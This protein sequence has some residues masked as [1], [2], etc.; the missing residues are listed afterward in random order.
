MNTQPKKPRPVLIGVGQMVHHPQ[1]VDE[2]KS[3]LD[4]IDVA[5]RRAEE[6]CGQPGLAAKIDTLQLVNII[7]WT[8]DPPLKMLAARLGANP[9][10]SGYTWIGASAPQWFVNRTAEMIVSGQAR[11]A[12]ICGG[13]AFYSRKLIIKARRATNQARRSGR[14]NKTPDMVGDLRDPLTALELKYGLIQP[15]EI[16]PLYENGLRSF[17]GWS[18]EEHR[19]ELSEFC[20]SMSAQAAGN[21]YAWFP[22]SRTAEEIAGMS[23][24]NRMISFPY[25]KLMCSIMDVDQAAAVF[26][27]N[28]ETAAELGVPREKWVYLLGAGDAS[29]IWHPTERLN[30]HSSPS[31]KTAADTALE[32]AGLGLEEIDHLDFYSCFPCAPRITRNMLGIPKGDPR[33][34]TITGGMPYFGGPGNNYALHAI[35]HMVELLREKP[36]AKGL[37]QALSWF[38]SKHAVGVYSAQ[39]GPEPW[40]PVPIKSYQAELDKLEGPPMVEEISGK[41]T[42]ETYTIFYDREG[43]PDSGVVVGR[44]NSGE[45]FLAKTEGDRETYESLVAEE[46]IGRQGRVHNKDGLN[47]FDF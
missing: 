40:E 19:Q 8:D 31:V 11:L 46:L 2:A 12:L 35:S 22:R 13:E 3:P 17:E 42:V 16:Y 41:A 5:I 37:C 18:I 36:S 33:P 21:Q 28:E 43:Q 44:L 4:H 7:S 10:N 6:D 47:Y 1:S 24:G 29:D 26:M 20:A 45:R 25:T 34:L 27:T 32:Q 23:G 30:F 38:I 14:M 15:I 39:P 9:A